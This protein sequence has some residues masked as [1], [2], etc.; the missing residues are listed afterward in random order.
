MNALI[1]HP[2]EVIRAIMERRG[3]SQDRL[4]RESGVSQSL[5]SRV[6]SDPSLR[7]SGRSIEKLIP[8]TRGK[9]G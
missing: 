9:R 6:L 4:A 7:L 3:W 8:F 2:S 1:D 5:I